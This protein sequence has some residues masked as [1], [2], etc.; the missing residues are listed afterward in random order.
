MK[1]PTIY[2]TADRIK[3]TNTYKNANKVQQLILTKAFNVQRVQHGVNVT[4]YSNLTKWL[5][6][7]EPTN[8]VKLVVIDIVAASSFPTGNY[9][10]YDYNY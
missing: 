5:E 3:Q 10:I 6:L 7:A 4:T 1:A 2:I 9:K 8:L